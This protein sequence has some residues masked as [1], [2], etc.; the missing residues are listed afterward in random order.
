VKGSSAETSQFSSFFSMASGDSWSAGG[1]WSSA[2]ATFDAPRPLFDVIAAA[3]GGE[4]DRAKRPSGLCDE[5]ELAGLHAL[6]AAAFP[7]RK[8]TCIQ[9]KTTPTGDSMAA[10]AVVLSSSDEEMPDCLQVKRLPA[11]VDGYGESATTTAAAAA[12][13]AAAATT[14]EQ[15]ADCERR[16]NGGS[17]HPSGPPAWIHD[18]PAL[19]FE[20]SM[21]SRAILGRFD[22]T[23]IVRE[24]NSS[25]APS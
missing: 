7:T 16:F 20:T 18:A 4:D 21:C 8:S 10:A 9:S 19:Q 1:E 17:S 25:L 24:Q 3:G 14:T 23:W 6:I 5:L 12:A 13:A 11:T 15:G 2:S 22:I